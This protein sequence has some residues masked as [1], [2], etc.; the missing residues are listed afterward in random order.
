MLLFFALLF[1]VL[2]IIAGL[3]GFTDVMAASIGIAQVLFLIFFILFVFSLV[4]FILRQMGQ[5]VSDTF[6]GGAGLIAW[7]LT[8]FVIAFVAGLLGF[9]GIMTATAGVAKF[10]F[11]VFLILFV[12]SIFVHLFQGKEKS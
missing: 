1:F 12:I 3:L 7:I 5:A 10:L 8:F 2:S 11:V 4:L 6:K 9:T